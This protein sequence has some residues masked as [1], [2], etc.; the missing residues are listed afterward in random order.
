[1][2]GA[3]VTVDGSVRTRQAVIEAGDR[4]ASALAAAGVGAGDAVAVLARSDFE[5]DLAVRRLDAFSVPVNWHL[6]PEEV[7]YVLEDSGARVLIG[8]ADLI[9]AA[10][11]AVPAGVT[12]VAVDPAPGSGDRQ[13]AP[14]RADVR[15]HEWIA[16]F[17][18]SRAEGTGRGSSMIY[19]SGT[20]GRPKAVRRLA[21]N[22]DE[23]AHRQRLLALIYDAH[24]ENVALVTGPMHHL[25][26]HA[27][28]MSN[29]SAGASV[30]VMTR[31]DP[32]ETLRLIEAH[33]VTHT[34][35]VPTM[36]V[37]L[38]RLPDAV[39]A[40]YDISSLRHVTQSGASC[41]PEVK[42]AMLDWFGPIIHETYGST[43]TGVVTRISGEEWCQRQT[44][45]GRPVL[46]G[47]VRVLDEAGGDVPAGTVG[48][49]FL[50]MHG[51]PDF[52][53]HGD[54]AKRAAMERDGLVSVGDLGW[55]DADG[56]LHIS[57]RKTDMLICGGAN[58]YPPE[59]ESALLSHPG[60]TDAVV[61]G[62]PDADYGEIA[63][64]HVDAEEGL[65]AEQIAAFLHG[66]IAR[67]KCPRR[68][69]VDHAI[70]RAEN[71][72]LLKRLLRDR[73]HEVTA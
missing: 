67:Y 24:P 7:R 38:L 64:A 16:R 4:L 28:A 63:V 33:G 70:P 45:V 11:D 51:T 65:G 15:Y 30:V 55:L 23:A 59:I 49:V 72:K 46:T 69:V 21:A 20:T 68:I 25:F 71:G 32:E 26:S 43:E 5:V 54:P 57:G 8:H 3:T 40:R 44:S 37:R 73:Y 29:F 1:M 14:A 41:A 6:H 58:I 22:A 9:D 52:T 66:R 13:A 39:K 17:P 27:T 19:T 61:F 60:V 50:R 47:E 62:I 35:F 18:P 31:F 34:S 36:L 10:G 12:V 42:R 2:S 53:Y 48:E 56:Y